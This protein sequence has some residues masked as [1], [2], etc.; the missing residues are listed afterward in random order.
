MNISE[1]VERKENRTIRTIGRRSFLRVTAIAGGGILL[2]AYID[3]FENGFAKAAQAPPAPNLN[4]NAFITISREGI[5]TIIAKN[6]E[7]GQNVKT[8]LP[9]LIAEE[10]DVDWKDVRIEQGDV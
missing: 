9:M 1:A 10:L 3:P 7:V 5:A 6:P 2:A 8:M 4:P